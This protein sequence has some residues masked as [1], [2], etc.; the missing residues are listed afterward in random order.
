MR[1]VA[2]HNPRNNGHVVCGSGHPSRQNGVKVGRT[3]S[4]RVENGLIFRMWPSPFLLD[5]VAKLLYGCSILWP[6]GVKSV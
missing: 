1:Q 6:E 2:L 3:A 5:G 4:F